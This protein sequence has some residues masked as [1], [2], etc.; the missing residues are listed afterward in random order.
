MTVRVAELEGSMNPLEDSLRIGAEKIQSLESELE[1]REALLKKM[2]EGL[3]AQVKH[4]ELL[5]RRLMGYID[6]EEISKNITIDF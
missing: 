4:S 5:N 6:R 3:E 1:S 2:Q